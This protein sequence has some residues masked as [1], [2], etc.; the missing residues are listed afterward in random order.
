[1]KNCRVHPAHWLI[2]TQ[3]ST[4]Q[5]AL[6]TDA[7]Q[8]IGTKHARGACGVA[9]SITKAASTHTSPRNRQRRQSPSRRGANRAVAAKLATMPDASRESHTTVR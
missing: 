3:A 9:S 6:S 8:S 1:M 7:A 2:S 5:S 4:P